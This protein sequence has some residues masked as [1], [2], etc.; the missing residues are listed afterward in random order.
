MSNFDG[1]QF[2]DGLLLVI[3]II[4]LLFGS[5]DLQGITNAP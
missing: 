1:V 2:V 4:L 3:L 5:R